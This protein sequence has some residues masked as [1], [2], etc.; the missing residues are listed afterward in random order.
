MVP[1]H[2][3]QFYNNLTTLMGAYDYVYDN[4]SSDT[5]RPIE[6]VLTQ[7]SHAQLNPAKKLYVFDGTTNTSTYHYVY[8]VCFL[9]C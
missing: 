8:G 9:Y 3:T 6:V 4:E 5:P 7:Y 1:V 2:S